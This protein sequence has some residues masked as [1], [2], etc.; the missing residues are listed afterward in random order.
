MSAFSS[1]VGRLSDLSE[2]ELRQLYLIVGVRLGF[3]DGQA[4]KSSQ[5]GGRSSGKSSGSVKGGP[6]KGLSAKGGKSKSSKGNPQRKSQW[7]THPLYREYKRL[8]K[9]VEVQAKEGNLPFASVDT[10][11]RGA[12][13][14]ALEAWLGAKSSF[15]DHDAGPKEGEEV[16]S[17]KG[18]GRAGAPAQA[19]GD[20]SVPSPTGKASSRSS[21]ADE[22]QEAA[23]G[24]SS[25]EDE[26][27]PDAPEVGVARPPAK[28]T[29]IVDRRETPAHD[30]P[31]PPKNLGGAKKNKQ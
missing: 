5:P 13:N 4:G 15:R 8:K 7:E 23:D 11:E 29:P 16:S 31:T 14:L 21:W 20:T 24:A 10:P 2:S 28:G 17:S 22:A 18:K 25:S 30:K 9:V 19:A 3:P 27:L 12:Y 26:D 1:V 6:K